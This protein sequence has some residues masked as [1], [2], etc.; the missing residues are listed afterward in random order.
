MSATDGPRGAIEVGRVI[1]DT[2]GVIGRNFVPFFIMSLLLTGLPT[3]VFGFLNPT[4]GDPGA[5]A[6]SGFLTLLGVLVS[7]VTGSVLQG[8]LVHGTIMDMNER[9]AALSVSLAVGLRAFLPLIAIGLLLGVALA[10][11]FLL[12]IVPGIIMAV[13]WSVVVPAYIGERTGIFE[14]FTRSR[15]LTRGNRWRIFGLAIL[16]IVAVLI[17]LMVMAVFYGFLGDN[18]FF[19]NVILTPLITSLYGMLGAAGAA[20]LYVHLRRAKEGMG[21]ETLAAIFD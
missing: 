21:P 9:R 1:Q 4:A 2:F 18:A 10:L 12:L 20:V 6:E 3:A 15:Q 17:L 8:A 16:Y 11:G 13:A 7:M 5:S 19:D 14:A